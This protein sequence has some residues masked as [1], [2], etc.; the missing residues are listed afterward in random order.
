MPRALPGGGGMGGF[1]IDWYI[2][3]KFEKKRN[4][5]LVFA[6]GREV[7]FEICPSLHAAFISVW[8]NRT[9]C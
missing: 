2:I 1:G 4:K 6:W 9:F 7:I 3:W 5:T 8:R